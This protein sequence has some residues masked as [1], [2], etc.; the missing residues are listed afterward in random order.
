[1]CIDFSQFEE[2]E[3]PAHR[4]IV[5][6]L[7]YVTEGN[8]DATPFY[9]GETSR[10]VGRFGD[11]LSAKF[12]ACTDFKVGEAVKYLRLRG[13]RVI[14]KYKESTDRQGEEK[15]IL[16]QFRLQHRLLL[17]D[18][19][20]YDYRR[21][22]ELDERRKIRVFMSRIIENPLRK[23]EDDRASG[24]PTPGVENGTGVPS[25]TK[26]IMGRHL[27]IPKRIE[28]ICEKLGEGGK[29]IKRRDILHLAKEDGIKE[30][31]VLPADYCE[32][33]R[34]GKWSNQKFL[35]LVKPGI[36]VLRRFAAKT[37]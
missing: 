18:L 30:S 20:G 23:K 10:H 6:L 21:S 1:M 35:H 26:S 25:V 16:D 7:Y 12:S 11:Y 15:T 33:T 13:F 31:S 8:S 27:T 22:N 17:N 28:V 36:Y 14:I 24:K 37:N 4:D 3:F 9:V 34:T 2:M 5:Y 29:K 32:N 19:P